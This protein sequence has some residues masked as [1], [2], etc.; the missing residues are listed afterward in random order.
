MRRRLHWRIRDQ[1]RWLVSVLKGHYNY[2]GVP[3]N[4]RA[5]ASFR[6]W[7]RQRWHQILQRRSQKAR[8]NRRKLDAIDKRFPR[9]ASG[10]ADRLRREG[11]RV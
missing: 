9:V 6:Y 10:F 1:W 4:Y 5:L 2:Y 3:S 8:L 7:V 11:T